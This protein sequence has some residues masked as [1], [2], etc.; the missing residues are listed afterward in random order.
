MFLLLV[1]LWLRLAYL[2]TSVYHP[3][4][5]ISMLAA[6]MVSQKGLPFLP[7]G[8]FYDHGLLYSL[9]SGGLIA[10]VGFSEA[11]ARWPVILVSTFTIAAY[12]T[13]ARTLFDSRLTGLLAAALITFDVFAIKW[14][15]WA[16]G[17]AQ[18]HLFILLGV[19]W[20][21]SSSLKRPSVSGRY[22]TL[23]LMTGAVFSHTLTLFSLPPLVLLLFFF[24]LTYRRDWLKQPGVWLQ[25]LVG[26]I[27]LTAAFIIIQAGHIGSTV[28]LQDAQADVPPPFGL[29][30]LRG[31]FLPGIEWSRFQKLIEFYNEPFYLLLGSIIGITLV[32]VLY[33]LSKILVE[34]ASRRSEG[35]RSDRADHEFSLKSLTFHVSRFTERA[36]WA[37]IAFLFLAL[38]GLIV[39][40]EMA[41]LL[42][43]EWL[44]SRYMFFLTLPVFLLLGAQGLAGALKWLFNL[45]SKILGAKRIGLRL[46]WNPLPSR[47]RDIVTPLAST[48]IVMIV[49]GPAARDTV[50]AQTTG[51]L[52]LGQNDYY[53]NQVTAKVLVSATTPPAI[54]DR[55]TASPLID[56]AEKFNQVMDTG[57][58]IWLVVESAHLNKYY[59]PILHSQIFARMDYVRRFGETYIFKSQPFSVPL[60]AEPTGLLDGN[61]GDFIYLEGFSIDPQIRLPDETTLFG[62]YWRPSGDLPADPL[63]VFVQLRNNRNETIS[64]ADHA[65]FEGTLTPRRWK[66]LREEE[67]WLRDSTYLRLPNPLPIADGPYRIYVGL[68]NPDTFERVPIL[69]DASGENAAVIDLSALLNPPPF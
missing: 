9:L 22:L 54:V 58:T 45:A 57:Q 5:F 40:T 18:A 37:D 10:L 52:Y 33:R 53:L 41:V 3:D 46:N 11:I 61:F 62:L 35:R 31:F 21:L 59:D 68:Y 36:Y 66:K 14:G 56:T 51:Y 15:V 43:D 2:Q 1:G 12:Y 39:I 49:W 47:Y 7:S 69:N 60:P 38:Y 20:L 23:L 44:E 17:Y 8:L 32:A 64:Q 67:A 29:E 16:R 34:D 19:T 50:D 6:K 28:S 24:T 4:E 26:L 42:T 25:A 65:I 30:F 48:L 63:K 55:Y 27:I 13:A